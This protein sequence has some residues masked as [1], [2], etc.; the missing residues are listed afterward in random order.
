M[1]FISLAQ[2]KRDTG[3][4]YIGQINNGAKHKKAFK[5]KELVY[6][7][8]FAPARSCGYEVCPGRTRECTAACL[9]M[10][11]HNRMDMK[12]EMINKSRIK[13]TRLFFEEREFTVRWIIEEITNG[14]MKANRMGYE[15]SV[16]LNN[17]SDISPEEFYIYDNGIKKNLL[18]LFPEIMFYDYTKVPERI[19]LLP[20]Y[21][22]YDLTYSFNGYNMNI[23]L[24]MLRRNVRVA[25]VFNGV[26]PD[27]F[28]GHPVINGDLYDMRYKDDTNVI[29]GL[30][31]KRVRTKLNPDNKFVIQQ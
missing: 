2:A 21:P 14:I 8:Y 7:I 15:F 29:T 18:Q 6:T 24:G 12:K 5:Y 9:N 17:T 20:K 3:L 4:S 23:C 10:S 30:H 22:N 11:G 31:Y 19:A 1:E 26:L 25:I 28:M 27:T 13:K 16:R